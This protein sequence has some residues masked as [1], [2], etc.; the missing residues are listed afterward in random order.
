[1]LTVN[2]LRTG[3]LG[4]GTD[5]KLRVVVEGQTLDEVSGKEARDMAMTKAGEVGYGNAGFSDSP[6]IG[7][8]DT[9]TGEMLDGVAALD[10]KR[11]RSG[12]RAEFT[13]AKRL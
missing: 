2:E 6:D 5:G 11:E 9:A 3:T 7:A 8:I 13:F 12:Y 4:T 1:M 10:P